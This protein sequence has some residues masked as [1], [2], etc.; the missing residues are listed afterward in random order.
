[1]KQLLLRAYTCSYNTLYDSAV[2]WIEPIDDVLLNIQDD[3]DSA[4]IEATEQEILEV[5]SAWLLNVNDI[6]MP[7]GHTIPDEIR[8]EVRDSFNG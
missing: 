5:F 1:M 2:S 4:G 3:L 6:C 8:L 7:L